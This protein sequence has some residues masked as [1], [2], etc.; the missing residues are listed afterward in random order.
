[1][2][3]E[4]PEMNTMLRRMAE[5]ASAVTLK[6]IE[7]AKTVMQGAKSIADYAKQLPKGKHDYNI[8]IKTYNRRPMNKGKRTKAM[9]G[10]AISSAISAMQA[11]G[12]MQQPLPS[13][14]KGGIF[15]GQSG[16]KIID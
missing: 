15:E 8:F 3:H 2:E 12:I 5:N 6:Q 13:F 9:M 4:L 10:M 16:Y 7:I 11:C 14:I 1:M